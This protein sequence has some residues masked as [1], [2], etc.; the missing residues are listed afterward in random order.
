[1]R[2]QSD[3]V[4]G[5]RL[6]PSGL[7]DVASSS[8]SKFP[9][10]VMR[11]GGLLLTRRIVESC[12]FANGAHVV[13]VGCGTGITVEYLRDSYGL[14]AVGVDVSDAR[15]EQG[16]KRA[17]D[18]HLIRAAGEALPFAD[19]SMDGAL[20]E[21]SLS[22]MRDVGK[23]LTEIHR[24]LVPGGKL[25]LTDLYTPDSCSTS[26]AGKRPSLSELT[27]VMKRGELTKL[28]TDAGF[29]VIQWEDQSAVLKEFVARF[30]MECGS[31]EELW[32]CIALR[33]DAGQVCRPAVKPARL[34][35][36][37]LVAEKR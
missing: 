10:G 30:I 17:A 18:L 32:L 22:V 7:G 33:K 27:G 3:S 31:A 23:V 29:S 20:A 28:L 19:G 25:A 24:I 37:L 12:A 1:M 11:P 14:R 34:G 36:F 15:L 6:C 35:Y 26:A 2:S 13:D 9:D 8:F 16:R 4:E 21:C 5:A